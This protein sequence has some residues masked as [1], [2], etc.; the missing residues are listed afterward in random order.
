MSDYETNQEYEDGYEN[1]MNIDELTMI[2]IEMIRLRDMMLE[3]AD[4]SKK[5]WDNKIV[6]F[7]VSDDCNTCE[8]LR[9]DDFSKFL[10]F[11]HTQRTYQ[12]M[13]DQYKRLNNRKRYL[14]RNNKK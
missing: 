1:M 7:I 6:P 11:M 12:L 4:C 2:D 9:T 5:I 13:I 14:L 10:D 3:Y 8:Y